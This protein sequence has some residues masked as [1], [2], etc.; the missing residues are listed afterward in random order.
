MAGSL[1]LVAVE[2]TGLDSHRTGPDAHDDGR[3]LEDLGQMMIDRVADHGASHRV[4]G[5]EWGEAFARGQGDPHLPVAAAEPVLC[6]QH[7]L[8]GVSVRVPAIDEPL[9]P[10]PHR[11]LAIWKR[12]ALEVKGTDKSAADSKR[13]RREP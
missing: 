1:R 5:A 6:R 11:K 4:I 2:H 12:E 13:R 9:A 8:V 3:S 10:G 7:Q